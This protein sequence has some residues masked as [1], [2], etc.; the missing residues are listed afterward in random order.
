M[1]QS[2]QDYLESIIESCD[3]LDT[4]TGT[5]QERAVDYSQG[6]MHIRQTA[7]AA[8]QQINAKPRQTFKQQALELN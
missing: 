7:R 6:L 5:V 1:S 3:I 4:V 8:I 2:I